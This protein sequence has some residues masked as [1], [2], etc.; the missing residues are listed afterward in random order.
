MKAMILAAGKGTRLAPLTDSA[1]KPLV[2]VCGTP[3]IVH[4]IDRLKELGV[5]ELVINTHH[6]AVMLE[7]FITRN[8]SFG[9]KIHISHEPE[10]LDTG[11]GVLQARRFLEQSDFF[12]LHNADVYSEIDLAALVDRHLTEDADATLAIQKREASRRLLFSRQGTLLGWENADSGLKMVVQEYNENLPT[13]PAGFCGIHVLRPSLF[14]IL[15]A[16]R[17]SKFSIIT[18]YLAAVEAGLRIASFD[19][20]ESPWFDLGSIDK[21]REFESY[22]NSKRQ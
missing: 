19:I 5:D 1:P 7:E 22:K 12:L 17:Q 2:P 3:M 18:A 20:G 10:L 8:V 16:Q 21:I 14:P 11:G 9:I 15:V 13:V 4:V 6:H